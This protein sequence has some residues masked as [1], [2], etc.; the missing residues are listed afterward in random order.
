MRETNAVLVTLRFNQET[1]SNDWI[2]PPSFKSTVGSA[3]FHRQ[4]SNRTR[5]EKREVDVSFFLLLLFVCDFAIE[6]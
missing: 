4:I 2:L 5:E 6:L 1:G 3:S